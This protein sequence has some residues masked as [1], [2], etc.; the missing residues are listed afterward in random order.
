M[1]TDLVDG[2]VDD[3][4]QRHLL[5]R[6]AGRRASSV[7]VGGEIIERAAACVPPI[8]RLAVGKNGYSSNNRHEP[9][10]I[11][12]R[13]STGLTQVASTNSRVCR[14]HDY[15]PARPDQPGPEFAPTA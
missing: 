10:P 14:Q 8:R 7:E 15:R 13:T 6:R 12:I 1:G 11:S 3:Q 5:G 9:S 2:V 4:V